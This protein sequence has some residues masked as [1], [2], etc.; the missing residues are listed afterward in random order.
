MQE[1]EKSGAKKMHRTLEVSLS[2][3]NSMSASAA[4]DGITRL[5]LATDAAG[6]LSQISLARSYIGRT[7]VNLTNAST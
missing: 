6:Q 2:A 5:N 3:A 4:Q 7:A 1:V